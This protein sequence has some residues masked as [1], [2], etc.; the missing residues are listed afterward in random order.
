MVTKTIP[1]KTVTLCDRCGKDMT[2]AG[3][4]LKG[5]RGYYAPDG[6]V[7]GGD[8]TLDLCHK[9]SSA[10]DKWLANNG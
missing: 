5:K 10:L 2:A 6:V 3:T 1:E 4:M 8:M 9:C 7:A